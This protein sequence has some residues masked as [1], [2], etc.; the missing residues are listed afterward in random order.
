MHSLVG[1]REVNQGV[2]VDPGH[3]AGD[4]QVRGV[5]LRR[6]SGQD[7]DTGGRG[8]ENTGLGMYQ[9]DLDDITMWESEI[10]WDLYN[11][12]LIEKDRQ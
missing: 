11:P 2:G 12:I 6:A 8:W 1:P 9:D 4:I 3:G 7:P 10:L 5:S